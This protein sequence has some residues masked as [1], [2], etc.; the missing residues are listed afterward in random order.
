MSLPVYNYTFVRKHYFD[1]VSV[2]D[3]FS[4][5]GGKGVA[6]VN[7]QTTQFYQHILNT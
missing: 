7:I 5:V 2:M 6:E 3:N 1:F 4:S